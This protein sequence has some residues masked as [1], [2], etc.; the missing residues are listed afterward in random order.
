M[1]FTLTNISILKY[2]SVDPGYE[3]IPSTS[4]DLIFEPETGKQYEITVNVDS[5]KVF[6]SIGFDLNWDEELL[7]PI[8]IDGAVQQIDGSL[9]VGSDYDLIANYFENERRIYIT[10]ALKDSEASNTVGDNSIITI[11]VTPVETGES[12]NV[13]L[14]FREVTE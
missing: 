2:V 14:T 8:V 3:I 13:Y 5:E 1:N 9:F 12:V 10:K 6:D 11:T 4:Q 7:K